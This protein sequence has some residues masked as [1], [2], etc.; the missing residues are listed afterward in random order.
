MLYSSRNCLF[1][2][3]CL[4]IN[5][6]VRLSPFPYH[7]QVETI[8]DKLS[9]EL[10]YTHHSRPTSRRSLVILHVHAHIYKIRKDKEGKG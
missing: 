2:V 3:K 7:F 8:H 9:V 4:G 5:G 10:F 1:S 6:A